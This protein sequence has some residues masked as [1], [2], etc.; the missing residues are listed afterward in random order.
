MVQCDPLAPQRVI[1]QGRQDGAARS[2]FSLTVSSPGAAVSS[3]AVVIA[4]R[5]GLAFAALAL[6]RLAPLTGLWLT[7]F[8][9]QRYSNNDD[10]AA[11]RM[12]GGNAAEHVETVRAFLFLGVVTDL[13]R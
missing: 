10:S 11:S 3:R 12:P 8:F 7:A 5:R 9:S 1:E 2:R 6:G 4:E 13:A